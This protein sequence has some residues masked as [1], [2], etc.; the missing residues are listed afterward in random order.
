MSLILWRGSRL[1][2]SQAD[3]LHLTYIHLYIHTYILIIVRVHNRLQ[4]VLV[5][6][7]GDTLFAE[8]GLGSS[9]RPVALTQELS[10]ALTEV[11]IHSY[12]HTYIH[13]YW[14]CT[15]RL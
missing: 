14:H 5:T 10:L 12:I 8:L 6:L 4:A 3:R 9:E 13:T 15:I 1:H 11:D 7:T 2:R